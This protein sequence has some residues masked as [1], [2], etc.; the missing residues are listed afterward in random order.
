MK[1]IVVLAIASVALGASTTGLAQGHEGRGRGAQG[2]MS[3]IHALMADHAKIERKVKRLPNGIETITESKDQTVA[4]NIQAHVLA[5]KTRLEKGWPIRRW[6]PL[7]DAI[8][9][10]RQH[11]T[12]KV[13]KTKHGVRVVETSDDPFAVKLLHAHADTV[14]LFV[15]HG[16]KEMHQAHPVP[17]KG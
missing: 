11:L 2:D 16:M 15:K 10:N 3:I 8:F 13:E 1:E 6:D 7:F 14:S 4:A 17:K 9:A 5:M 12:M